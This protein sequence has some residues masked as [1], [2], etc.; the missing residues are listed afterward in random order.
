M[1]KN[2]LGFLSADDVD[3]YDENEY[4]DFEDTSKDDERA[5]KRVERTSNDKILK[6]SSSSNGNQ[7]IELFKPKKMEEAKNIA[8]AIKANKVCI[9]SIVNTETDEDSQS[10]ADYL[11]G[12]TFVLGGK[13]TKL[14]DYIFMASPASIEI[15]GSFAELLQSNKSFF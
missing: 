9:V 4:E 1:L 10:I 12:A 7:K 15:T 5:A 14:N 13:I 3:Y 11:T 6:M 8:L 2:I